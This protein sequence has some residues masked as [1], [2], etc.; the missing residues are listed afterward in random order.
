MHDLHQ[1]ND[2]R[3]LRSGALLV[4]VVSAISTTHLIRVIRVL[5]P[6]VQVNCVKERERESWRRRVTCMYVYGIDEEKII[7][8]VRIHECTKRK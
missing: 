5:Y 8:C 2:E 7:A 1:L 3:F 6:G 4:L